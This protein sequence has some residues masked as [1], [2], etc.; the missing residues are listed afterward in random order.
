MEWQSWLFMFSFSVAFSTHSFSPWLLFLSS[1]FRSLCFERSYWFS[2]IKTLCHWLFFLFHRL[3]SPPFPLF[4]FLL[5]CNYIF[6]LF[7]TFL[8]SC[9]LLCVSCPLFVCY[10]LFPKLPF[11]S[12]HFSFCC[13]ILVFK[14]CFFFAFLSSYLLLS[15]FL[16]VFLRTFLSFLYLSLSRFLS[17]LSS[18][19]SF[20]KILLFLFSSLHA[21]PPPPSP[22]C[23]LTLLSAMFYF[24]LSFKFLCF[25][26]FVF[27]FF[28]FIF[29]HLSF[30]SSYL[31][32]LLTFDSFF[33]K[34]LPFYLHSPIWTSA[35]L[36]FTLITSSSSLSLSHFFSHHFLS[37]QVPSAFIYFISFDSSCLT[38][39]CFLFC[40]PS[41]STRSLHLTKVS[42]HPLTL[43]VFGLLSVMWYWAV[44]TDSL[45]DKEGGDRDRRETHAER[46]RSFFFLQ[47]LEASLTFCTQA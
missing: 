34:F 29:W 4:L 17:F 13:I 11:Y 12:S 42:P 26:H 6:L 28:L 20:F 32:V 35:W 41:F 25:L 43:P 9:F 3:P 27:S 1:F 15:F 7:F 31:S 14:L 39:F 5:L 23:L 30:L 21:S 36:T 44:A 18:P 2:Y 38:V 46:E 37:S 16:A 40:P 24:F 10:F 33:R 22:V 8:S 45:W 19:S 47:T